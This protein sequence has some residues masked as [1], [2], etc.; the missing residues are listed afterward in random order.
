MI[1]NPGTPAPDQP[2]PPKGLRRASA[3]ALTA[4]LLAALSGC[5]T[6]TGALHS[7]SAPEDT[8]AAEAFATGHEVPD[9]ALPALTVVSG[10]G[11][12][13]TPPLAD[14]DLLERIRHQLSLPVSDDPAVARELKWFA[15]HPD[16][17]ARVFKR[18][19]RYL[20]HIV[21]TLEQRNMPL[22]LALLPIVESAFDPFAYSHGRASGLWQIIPGTGRRL[23]LKQNWWYDGRRDIVE[24]TRAALDYLESMHQSFDQDWLLAVAGYNSGEGNVAR[25]LRR[26]ASSAQDQDFWHIRAYLPVETRTYVPRLLALAS[27]LADPAAHGVDL[28]ALPN[29]P[30]FAAVDTG[31]Q[32]DLALAAELASIDT[33]E[34]YQLNPGFNR[35]ATDPDGP[36]RLLVPAPVST[37][38]AEALAALGDR[39]RVQWSRHRIKQ[40]ETL[41]V[42]ARHYQTT[43]AVLQEVNK[44]DGH[45]IRAGDYL[46]IPHAV[47]SMASYTQTADARAER[48]RNTPRSGT[49]V[50]HVV[51]PG[52]SLW[53]IS[54]RYGVG[55]REL[56]A[57][58]SMAP[59]DV[60]S[61]GREL[62][63]WTRSTDAAPV[64]S[65]TA[66][67]TGA[68]R[69]RRVTYQV[70]KGDSLSSIAS[71]FRVR[72]AELLQWNKISAE[73]YLQPGQRLVMYVD[74]TAQST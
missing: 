73:R 39:E 37:D 12:V 56:S 4:A 20:Y 68:E 30:Y 29:Q 9:A 45:L 40:G 50:A 6:V 33:D 36:H 62:V 51:Q 71:R 7:R 54:R 35:W 26:G 61:V 63:I 16:Y 41:E 70:R 53:T 65:A 57:W 49:Q 69:I 24:S 47:K 27:L 44:I 48:K 3:P 25:A 34:L 67:D 18:S 28:P 13:I 74:V 2:S 64:A 23:G 59:G 58:N 72:V 5:Q 22:D 42:L 52:E 46:M 32:I 60:L 11:L 1:V 31:G 15:E 10:P 43:P 14:Q 21:E 38:F 66:V 17:L 8:A 19:E 55:V